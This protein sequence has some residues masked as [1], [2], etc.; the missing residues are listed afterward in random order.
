MFLRVT[1]TP[2]HILDLA[3]IEWRLGACVVHASSKGVKNYNSNRNS[4]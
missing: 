4:G 2:S 1:S 3:D